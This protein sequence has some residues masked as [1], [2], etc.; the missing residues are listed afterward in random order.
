MSSQ[1]VAEPLRYADHRVCPVTR[2]NDVFVETL[3]RVS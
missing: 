2:D 1:P 3:I